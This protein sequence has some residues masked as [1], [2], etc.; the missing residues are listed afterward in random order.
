MGTATCAAS[1]TASAALAKGAG[2]K[3]DALDGDRNKAR[4]FGVNR[5]APR[6]SQVGMLEQ[7]NGRCRL[8]AGRRSLGRDL[9]ERPHADPPVKP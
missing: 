3:A 5:F 7:S 2:S 1:G 6:R 8:V 4:V 9:A